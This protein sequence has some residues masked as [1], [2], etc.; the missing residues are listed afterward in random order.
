MRRLLGA[1]AAGATAQ[2][3]RAAERARKPAPT[4]DAQPLG[5]WGIKC[6]RERPGGKRSDR[7]SAER[8]T[9]SRDIEAK[10][11]S[12]DG[13]ERRLLKPQALHSAQERRTQTR[14]A[15]RTRPPTSG[16]IPPRRAIYPRL[17][18]DCARLDSSSSSSTRRCSPCRESSLAA[19]DGCGSAAHGCW[20]SSSSNAITSSSPWGVAPGSRSCASSSARAAPGASSAVPGVGGS[21]AGGHGI[22]LFAARAAASSSGLRRDTGSTI[23]GGVGAFALLH[24]LPFD[25]DPGATGAG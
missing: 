13:F 12:Q 9:S 20:C 10:T 23:I 22:P 18:V 2:L 5:R 15:R 4:R 19:G 6:S 14:I 24:R 7:E 25:T 17:H 16:R 21:V 3:R 11:R 1:P 8:D